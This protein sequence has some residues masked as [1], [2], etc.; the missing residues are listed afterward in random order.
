MKKTHI[1]NLLVLSAISTCVLASTAALAGSPVPNPAEINMIQQLKALNTNVKVVGNRMQAIAEANAKSHNHITPNQSII[2]AMLLNSAYAKNQATNKGQLT[3]QYIQGQLLALPDN[4]A[5]TGSGMLNSDAIQKRLQTDINLKYTLTALTP[6]SDSIYSNDPSVLSLVPMYQNMGLLPP[7]G[8]A[9]P[10]KSDLHDDYFNFNS[11]ITP[12]VLADKSPELAAAQNYVT[13]LTKSY[14][15]PTEGIDFKTFKE[16]L[17]EAQNATDK[18]SLYTQLMNDDNYRNYQLNTRSSMA[19]R[20]VAVS[21][22][23]H[24]IN[25]R[26]SVK[27]L[28]K[29]TGM[30]DSSGK[31]IDDASPLQVE[32]YLAHRRVDDPKW[33]AHVQAESAANVQRE[34]LVVL[35]EIEAQNYQ[36]HMDRERLLATISAQMAMGNAMANAMTKAQAQNLNQDIKKFT[37]PSQQQ[38][39]DEQKKKQ[40]AQQAKNQS[41][42]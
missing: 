7:R 38:Q 11:I 35:A 13:F 25:E 32:D 8:L 40:E 39:Q 20:S 22:F 5:E 10:Q 36:A 28:G 6:A 14:E 16:K 19:S 37:I 15:L 3:N 24:M 27:D 42:H 21:N 12:T 1:K 26:M 9:Q 18:M 33:Y 2:N 31:P 4:L 29:Q 30:V 23:E 34:T 41:N 17:A